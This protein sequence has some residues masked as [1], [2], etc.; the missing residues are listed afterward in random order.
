MYK[1]KGKTYDYEDDLLDA[2]EADKEDNRTYNKLYGYECEALLQN[3][4]KEIRDNIIGQMIDNGNIEYVK[5]EDDE[6]AQAYKAKIEGLC[7][8]DSMRT[9]EK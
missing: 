8:R 9:G 7:K 2:I 1:Y 3:H 6:E 5:D 4:W